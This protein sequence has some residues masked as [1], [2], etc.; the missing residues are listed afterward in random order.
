[1]KSGL[2]GGFILFIWGAVSW[3]VLPWQRN[4][5]QSFSDESDVRSTIS[6]NISGSGLYVLP[7]LNNYAGNPEKLAAAKERMREGPFA[8]VAVSA[9]GKN[10]NMVAG[11]IE[12]LILKIVAACLVTW[13]LLHTHPTDF[14]KSVKFVTVVGIVVALLATIPYAIW[15][16]F[17]GGF[18]IGS[19]IEIVFGW[20][21]AGLAIARIVKV[22]KHHG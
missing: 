2:I 15:F 10:P 11:A 1:M 4:Q 7:N 14:T 6:S 22:K 3:T 20:F 21:F 12:S 18:V 17:P 19:M 5:I 8:M 13:L 9:E 16:G